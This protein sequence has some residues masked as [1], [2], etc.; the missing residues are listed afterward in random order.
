MTEQEDTAVPEPGTTQDL[1]ETAQMVRAWLLRATR[2]NRSGREVFIG[3]D[4]DEAAAIADFID[5]LVD[6]LEAADAPAA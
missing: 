3:P 1:R 6:R 4:R 5:R 2:R